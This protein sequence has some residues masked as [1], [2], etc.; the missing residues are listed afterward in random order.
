MRPAAEFQAVAKPVLQNR[1]HDRAVPCSGFRPDELRGAGHGRLAC[2]QIADV[3]RDQA[4]ERTGQ[5]PL[6][7]NGAVCEHDFG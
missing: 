3:R 4:F 1:A 7:G 5:L 6:T 2:R